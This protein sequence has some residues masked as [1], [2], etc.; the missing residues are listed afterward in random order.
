ME[1]LIVWEMAVSGP[2]SR[3]TFTRAFLLIQRMANGT[4]QLVLPPLPAS[5]LLIG[6]MWVTPVEFVYL[7][8][9][10]MDDF[11]MRRSGW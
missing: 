2:N 9:I 11:V 5:R 7:A 3:P 8:S 1:F 6:I 10:Y 4:Y